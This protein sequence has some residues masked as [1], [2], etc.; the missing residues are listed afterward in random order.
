MARIYNPEQYGDNYQGSTQSR[1][2]NP[3]KAVDTSDQERQRSKQ[4]VANVNREIQFQQRN[5][6]M[7]STVL[8]AQQSVDKANMSATST[9]VQGLL[10]L[11]Q[12]AL[13]AMELAHK[14]QEEET[15]YNNQV[16]TE[17]NSPEAVSYTHLTLPTILRV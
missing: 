10:S 13:K 7:E 2:F 8:K 12:T 9:A 1:G 16:E 6:Q 5:H 14:E 15:N 3:I 11:S 17:F 4:Q